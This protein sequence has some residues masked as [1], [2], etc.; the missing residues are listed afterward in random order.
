MEI[1]EKGFI[2]NYEV[3]NMG[4]LKAGGSGEFDGRPYNAS[5]K[6]RCSNLVRDIDDILGEVDKEELIEFRIICDNNEEAGE[7]NKLFRALKANGVIV[8]FSG[9]LP[10]KS[11]NSDF[12]KVTVLSNAKSLIQKYH[13]DMKKAS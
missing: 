9:G 11:N 4:L 1:I 13:K 7:L 10:I 3:Q 12:M 5:L 8:N 2:V 6:I